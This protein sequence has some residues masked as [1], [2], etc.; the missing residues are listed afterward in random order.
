VFAYIGSG[1]GCLSVEDDKKGIVKRRNKIIVSAY[2]LLNHKP[3]IIEAE[4]ILSICLQHEIDHLSGILY[5]DHINKDHPETISP[6]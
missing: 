5:Y 2:D 1:E 6:D 3:T 4:G